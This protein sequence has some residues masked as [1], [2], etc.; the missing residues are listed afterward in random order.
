MTFTEKDA[1]L[2]RGAAKT[3]AQGKRASETPAV[4]KAKASGLKT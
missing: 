2:K 4:R 1:G 3:P